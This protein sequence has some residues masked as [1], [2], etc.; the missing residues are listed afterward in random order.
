MPPD[1][2]VSDIGMPRRGRLRADPARARGWT[3]R[4]RRTCPRSRS[5][6]SRAPKTRR[7]RSRPGISATSRSRSNRRCCAAPWNACSKKRRATRTRLRRLAERRLQT[8]ARVPGQGLTRATRSTVGERFRVRITSARCRRSRT[9]SSSFSSVV[10]D[11]RLVA[12]VDVRD[13]GFGAAHRRRD[14][15][16]HALAVLRQ[17]R[18]RGLERPHRLLGP[19]DAA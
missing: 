8:P 4:A 17:Q 12:H 16:E 19:F 14:L 11:A 10:C 6:R 18:H 9:L 15:R 5:R 3:M 7:R 1:L 2:L 13:V